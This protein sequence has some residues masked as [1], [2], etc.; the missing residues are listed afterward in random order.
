MTG[1]TLSVGRVSIRA[2][3]H[4]RQNGSWNER[5]LEPKNVKIPSCDTDDKLKLS[6]CSWW[7]KKAGL[8]SG[9]R[10]GAF[11]IT[12]QNEAPLACT[13]GVQCSKLRL[14]WGV[15]LGLPFW[16][17]QWKCSWSFMATVKHQRTFKIIFFLMGLSTQRSST[18]MFTT[19]KRQS[20]YCAVSFNCWI[21]HR[22][23]AGLMFLAKMTTWQLTP[24]PWLQRALHSLHSCL[25]KSRC[26]CGKK[27]VSTE[28]E[29]AFSRERFLL[30]AVA[31]LSP[32]P[33]SVCRHYNAKARH[34]HSCAECRPSLKRLAL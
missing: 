24:D 8:F 2:Y 13:S 9:T 18:N 10:E 17:P 29:S 5:K 25:G 27:A 31:R 20:M 33:T 1:Q 3:L 28:Y 26:I 12:L 23:R 34:I 6:N 32:D 7:N 14:I 15:L 19:S 22:I 11:Q 4:G 30:P 16:V 21:D